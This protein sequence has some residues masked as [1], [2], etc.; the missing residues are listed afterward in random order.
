MSSIQMKK[1]CIDKI[2]DLKR[3]NR[4]EVLK[5]LMLNIN[6]KLIQEH[7]DGCRINLDH[8]DEQKLR[9]LYGLIKYKLEN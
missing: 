4:E 3:D 7:I 1:F 6:E 9:S 8:L 5:F 2:N